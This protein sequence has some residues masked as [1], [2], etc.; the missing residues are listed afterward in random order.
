MNIEI[1][2]DNNPLLTEIESLVLGML[3][4]QQEKIAQ[5][6]DEECQERQGCEGEVAA[7]EGGDEW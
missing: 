1:N 3:E 2:A 5:Q 4:D 7:Q 6:R